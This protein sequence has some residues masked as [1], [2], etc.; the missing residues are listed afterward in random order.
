MLWGASDWPVHDISEEYLYSVHMLQHMALSYFL[1]PL[2]L[3][4]T[5]TWL[6]RTLIGD[7][8]VYRAVRVADP[9]GRGGR[10]VQRDGDDRPHPDARERV[11]RERRRCTTGCTCCS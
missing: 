2:A 1:P 9:A 11:G 3:L 5:P 8:R 10:A 4:A 6:A 7:G